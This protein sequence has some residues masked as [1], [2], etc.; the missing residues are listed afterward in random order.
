MTS[1]F[2]V[3]RAEADTPDFNYLCLPYFTKKQ[4]V[5][6]KYEQW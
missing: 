2:D 6:K 1:S 4:K 5:E 3:G